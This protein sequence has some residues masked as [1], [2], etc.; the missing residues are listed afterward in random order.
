M[1]PSRRTRGSQ[2]HFLRALC[3]VQRFPRSFSGCVR[4]QGQM[5][6]PCRIRLLVYSSLSCK[7]LYIKF[8][9]GSVV[10]LVRFG[11]GE[12]LKLLVLV[13]GDVFPL[14]C[15]A[16]CL[17]SVL[18]AL[19]LA[20]LLALSGSPSPAEVMC[21]VPGTVPVPYRHVL[22]HPISPYPSP[23]PCPAAPC[24]GTSPGCCAG[25]MST[26]P[27]RQGAHRERVSRVLKGTF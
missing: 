9:N 3:S 11:L 18:P 7:R 15:S 27:G 19:L 10:E 1:L 16:V 6:A 24:A 4:V 20:L 14:H 23:Q 5:V 17:G 12:L 8:L 25:G 13:P 22:L 26:S 2:E 21:G